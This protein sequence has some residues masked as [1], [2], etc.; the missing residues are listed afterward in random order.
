M[1]LFK[2]NFEI[3]AFLT[4]SLFLKIK[5]GRQNLAFLSEWPDSGKAFSELH[6]HYKSLLERVCD[7]AGFKEYG[8]DFAVALKMLDVFEK[9][10]T[11]VQSRGKKILLK[12]GSDPCF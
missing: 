4:H 12:I 7:H 3:L 6:I 1:F 5:K 9:K 2:P 8:K 10:C 11:T